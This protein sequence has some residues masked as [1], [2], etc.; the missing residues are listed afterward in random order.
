MSF[1]VRCVAALLALA[2]I[3]GCATQRVADEAPAPR[4]QIHAWSAQVL[5]G[6]RE[7]RYEVAHRGGRRCLLAQA[8]KSASL[9]RRRLKVDAAS[10]DKIEFDWWLGTAEPQA[11]VTSPDAD[12]APARLVLAFDGESGRLSPRNRLMFELMETLAGEPPPF[13]TLMYVWDGRAVAET[14]VVN[15]H[16]DR[17]RKIVLGSGADQHGRWQRFDRDLRA[18]YRRAYGEE[19][20]PLIGIALMTDAD[21]TRGRSEACYGMLRMNGMEQSTWTD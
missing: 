15:A 18:D 4:L 5:P 1:S 17:V 12:D 7:T 14:V 6:K 8:D 2:A 20:G 11:T 19:P 16:S 9:W 13:A 3:C 21:N 10:L